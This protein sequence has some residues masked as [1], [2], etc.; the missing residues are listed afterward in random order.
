MLVSH[1]RRK[2]QSAETAAGFLPRRSHHLRTALS[3]FSA[4]NATLISL[5]S[6]AV[7]IQINNGS[8]SGLALAFVSAALV[9]LPFALRD[10]E[11]AIFWPL[12]YSLLAWEL[13]ALWFA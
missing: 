2:S 13:L 10:R 9:S 5:F 6:I 11:T 12:A 7:G 3:H 8:R 1:N 4:P